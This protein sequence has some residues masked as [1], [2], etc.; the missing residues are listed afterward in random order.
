MHE[1]D[2]DLAELQELLDSSHAAAGA[3]LRSIFNEERRIPAV[4][5]PALLPGVQVLSLATVTAACEPRV[6][7]VDGLF[8]R[9][10]FWFGSSH[11]SARFRNIRARP[12]V[13]AAH[14]RGEELAVVVHGTAH[15]VD[16]A[17]PELAPFRNYCLEIY[18]EAWHDWGAPAAYARIDPTRM[19][20]FRSRGG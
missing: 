14:V 8:F 18:G 5:L 3:H 9:G 20:T 1:T 10:R 15:E 2:D 19:F 13:S 7:P 6:A 16:T 17:S 12:Q 4:E 11:D